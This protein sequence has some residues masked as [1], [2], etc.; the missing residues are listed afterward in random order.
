MNSTK[1]FSYIFAPLIQSTG[2]AINKD[3]LAV[4]ECQY[5][6]A[7]RQSMSVYQTPL[8]VKFANLAATWE[9]E[10]AHMSSIQGM[11]AHPAYSRIIAMGNDAVPLILKQLKTS[12]D[13]WFPAL[14][15][16]TG[17]DPIKSSDEG[18]MQAMTNAWL[19]WEKEY[20]HRL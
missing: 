4:T 2:M 10:T 13:Y 7:S 8:T 6:S 16:I 5:E 14:S 9:Y 3:L 18:D 19:N 12:P 11:V 17:V 15:A 1:I 20:V